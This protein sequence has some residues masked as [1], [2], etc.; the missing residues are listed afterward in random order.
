MIQ[1]LKYYLMHIL[2]CRRARIFHYSTTAA[3][4]PP[5]RDD[6]EVKKLNSASIDD[7]LAFHQRV[8]IKEWGHLFDRQELESRLESGHLC[9]LAR[10]HGDIVGFTWFSPATVHSPD[11]QCVFAA[12]RF[13]L[14][15][16]NTFIASKLRGRNINFHIKQRAFQDFARESYSHCYSYIRSDN[17]SSLKAADKLGGK[18]CGNIFYGY[19]M[20]VHFVFISTAPG[21]LR[22][23]RKRH[24]LALYGKLLSILFPG[25]R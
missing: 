18:A 15:N 17:R 5:E 22:I 14:I 23:S 10:R 24:P 2:S 21:G 1:T 13:S 25:K 16:Y 11:L 8:C 4:T 12:P 20:G 9:Y 7:L 6:I 19:L 3:A